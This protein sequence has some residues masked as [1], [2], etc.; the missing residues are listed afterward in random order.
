[1]YFVRKLKPPGFN[2]ETFLG[3][4]F[5][6]MFLF[7]LAF[8]SIFIAMGFSSIVL[9]GYTVIIA[10]VAFRTQNTGYFVLAFT[11]LVDAIFC[12]SLASLGFGGNKDLTT[13]L[14]ILVIIS[15]GFLFYMI[16][17]RRLKWRSRE[18]LELAAMPVKDV[19]NG[20]TSRPH[21][22]DRGEYS[23]EELLSFSRFLHTQLIAI[24][25][26]ESERVVF[27][28]TT[29][30]SRQLGMNRDYETGSWVAFDFHGHITAT[31]SKE[32]YNTYKDHYAFDQ[33]C[34][35]LGRVFLNFLEMYKK[36][37]GTMIIDQLN[38]LR[39]N[40]LIE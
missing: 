4:G 11:M 26:I 9:M 28:I 22:V 13:A 18:I 8:F 40:P 30:L 3:I 35:Q 27:S 21:P 20:F 33:L 6:V 38:S 15:F 7:L 16:A 2:T 1:M 12:A 19:S 29:P 5:G 34:D 10:I 39:L 32:D 24:P 23:R 25:F 37:N 17:N 31:I 14:A 36:G